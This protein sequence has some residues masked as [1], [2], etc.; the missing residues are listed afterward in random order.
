MLTFEEVLSGC[1]KDLGVR[2]RDYCE[3]CDGSGSES[4][5]S[6]TS[7]STCRGAGQVGRTQ[8]TLFGTFSSFATC[9]DCEGAGQNCKRPLPRVPWAR[10]G[11]QRIE[12]TS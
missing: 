12:H 8:S 7:C 6:T 1:E 3:A 9:P 4:E 5:D 11:R 2:K 10:S